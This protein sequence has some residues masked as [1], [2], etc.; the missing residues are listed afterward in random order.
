MICIFLIFLVYRKEVK[1]ATHHRLYAILLEYMEFEPEPAITDEARLRAQT[2]QV[3]LQP[4]DPFL[5][6]EDTPNPITTA[7][8]HRNIEPDSEDTADSSRLVQPSHGSL[9]ETPAKPSHSIPTIIAIVLISLIVGLGA[10][11]AYFTFLG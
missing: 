10:G 5:K 9:N 3:T 1:F 11:A 6:P 4:A 7:E 2:K 8:T